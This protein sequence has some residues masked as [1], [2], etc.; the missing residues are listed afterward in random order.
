M[1][2]KYTTQ[3]KLRGAEGERRPVA[4]ALDRPR[5]E[6]LRGG[7]GR[8]VGAE[9]AVPHAGGVVA[10]LG[11]APAQPLGHR[12]R[13]AGRPEHAAEPAA[14]L[15]PV[16]AGVGVLPVAAAPGLLVHL[17]LLVLEELHVLARRLAAAV[18]HVREQEPL[19]VLPLPRQHQN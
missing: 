11:V 13:A 6:L 8:L 15:V 10:P 12:A 7:A 17:A 18:L 2:R 5:P 3:D 1:S 16:P 19:D 9:V 4:R 14:D